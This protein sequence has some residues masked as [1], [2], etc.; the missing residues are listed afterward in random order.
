MKALVLLLILSVP[1]SVRSTDVIVVLTEYAK[2]EITESYVLGLSNG[3]IVSSDAA[4]G[5]AIPSIRKYEIR[6]AIHDALGIGRKDLCAGDKHLCSAQGILCQSTEDETDIVVIRREH[7][8]FRTPIAWLSAIS[9]HP[10]P[11]AEIWLITRTSNG[12]QNEQKIQQRISWSPRD[13]KVAEMPPNK[14]PL[15]MPVSGTPAA[16]A[17]VAPPPGIAGR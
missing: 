17:P 11:V 2:Q 5:R 15:R 16:D 13:A 3:R 7:I 10:I 6:P 9:G 12:R 1:L 14:P 4:T 8:Y